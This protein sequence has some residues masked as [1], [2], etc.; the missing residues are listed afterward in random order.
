VSLLAPGAS[1]ALAGPRKDVVYKLDGTQA[2]GS[3]QQF[4]PAGNFVEGSFNPTPLADGTLG[5]EVFVEWCAAFNCNYIIGLVP[6]SAVQIKSGK[7]RINVTASTFLQ[8]SSFSGDAGDFVGTF[9]PYTG[10]H[11]ASGSATG[12]DSSVEV[13]PDGSKT[14]FSFSGNESEKTANFVGILGPETVSAPPPGR[15]N[16]FIEM[17]T[18]NMREV[19]T[20]P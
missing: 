19:M 17:L 10:P 18:G 5:Y 3:F 11:S 4:E 6:A 7:V 1:A 13:S 12:N 9:T 2:S 15:S 8:V 16:G 20:A 14:T